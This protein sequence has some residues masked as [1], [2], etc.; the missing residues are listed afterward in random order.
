MCRSVPSYTSSSDCS[1][2][3][4]TCCSLRSPCSCRPMRI[5]GRSR[6]RMMISK[7]MQIF[8]KMVSGKTIV[9]E[10]DCA[11]NVKNVKSKI[12]DKEDI[13]PE[14]Q[15]LIF[16]GKQ[17][18]DSQTLADYNIRNESTLHLVL[19]LHAGMQQSQSHSAPS[20]MPS[21]DSGAGGSMMWMLGRKMCLIWRNQPMFHL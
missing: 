17:L 14:Q 19:R 2:L 20:L 1:S 21:P 16:A 6:S 18:E 11:E 15:R 10:V 4:R 9:L 5:D 12:M 8:V 7:K 3:F 13:P